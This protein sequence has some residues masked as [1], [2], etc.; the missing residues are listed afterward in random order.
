MLQEANKYNFLGVS[1]AIENV[2][3]IIAPAL[4]GKNLDLKDQSAIDKILLDLDKT[5]NKCK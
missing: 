5:E 3:K 4:V 1:K 2:N